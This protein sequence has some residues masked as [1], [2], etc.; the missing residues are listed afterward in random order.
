MTTM[1]FKTGDKE[2][3]LRMDAHFKHD[4]LASR[5]LITMIKEN[6][7]MGIEEDKREEF[8][9]LIKNWFAMSDTHPHILK[10]YVAWFDSWIDRFLKAEEEGKNLGRSEI[11]FL[12][13]LLYNV[14]STMTM[15]NSE[16]YN[17]DLIF[18]DYRRIVENFC[19]FPFVDFDRED[20]SSLSE[21]EQ[22]N[23]LGALFSLV[24]NELLFHDDLE[25]CF[26][27]AFKKFK[28]GFVGFEYMKK[29]EFFVKCK[30]EDK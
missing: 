3:T 21:D 8:V 25:T 13:I 17:D 12:Q 18:V 19:V 7:N 30:N 24:S 26:N 23:I 1:T 14:S 2:T 15:H 11:A 5:A 20:L 16:K 4:S 27:E 29:L 10:E 9:T 22:N 6:P 28:E